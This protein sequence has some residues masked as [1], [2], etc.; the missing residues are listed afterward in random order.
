[1]ALMNRSI[2]L[3][4]IKTAYSNAL[5]TGVDQVWYADTSVPG[6]EDFEDLTSDLGQ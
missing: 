4:I 5:P 1:M 6:R 3:G 2:M